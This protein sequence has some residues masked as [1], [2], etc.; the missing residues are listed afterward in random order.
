MKYRIEW[1]CAGYDKPLH[2]AIEAD[3]SDQAIAKLGEALTRLV[4]PGSVTKAFKE[5]LKSKPEWVISFGD[6]RYFLDGRNGTAPFV[7]AHR[8]KTE[9]D[10]KTVLEG[11][12]LE[13]C[14]I[15]AVLK[16]PP[17]CHEGAACSKDAPSP[18]VTPD[19]RDASR[20]DG[21]AALE[22]KVASLEAE[23]ARS[24]EDNANTRTRLLCE[25]DAAVLKE[26]NYWAMIFE[27]VINKQMRGLRSK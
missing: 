22:A 10:A 8:F 5:S 7:E 13:L 24:Y 26:K 18:H 25:R 11:L 3:S 17:V 16:A 9:E 12:P 15:G 6:H 1:Y 14:K 21:K 2:V 4:D 23:L 20:F 19:E 27:D